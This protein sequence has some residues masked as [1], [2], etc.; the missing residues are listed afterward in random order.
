M[1]QWE[2]GDGDPERGAGKERDDHPEAERT[3]PYELRT[4][5][6]HR[7]KRHVAERGNHEDATGRAT[8]T[9]HPR[10]PG[11]PDRQLSQRHKPVR[12]LPDDDHPS[13]EPSN[14]DHAGLKLAHGNDARRLLP[15][16]DHADRLLSDSEE[17][18]RRTV[19][20]VPAVWR[21]LR[22]T[23]SRR[24]VGRARVC[25]SRFGG[26]R[27]SGEIG[28]RAS[29]RGWCP[30]GR[31]GSSPPFDTKQ[32][33]DCQ[34]SRTVRAC[35][36]TEAVCQVGSHGLFVTGAGGFEG[37]RPGHCR[38]RSIDDLWLFGGLGDATASHIRKDM[39]GCGAGAANGCRI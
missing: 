26:P 28:R 16:R 6:P 13:G 7:C 10:D 14:G 24:S 4:H 9:D 27:R 22:G 37:D 34:G 25:R 2:R 36:S 12:H 33:F 19:E 11:D 3:S 31:G 5:L 8:D 23:V 18:H 32:M 29:L 35:G 17:A 38:S 21:E 1:C 20:H 39:G 30:K 15:E